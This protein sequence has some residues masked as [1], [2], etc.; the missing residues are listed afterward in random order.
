MHRHVIDVI[1]VAVHI[2]ALFLAVLSL[3]VVVVVV[4]S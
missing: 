4:L 1:V 3:R 2:T